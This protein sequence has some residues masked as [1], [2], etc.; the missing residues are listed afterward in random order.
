MQRAVETGLTVSMLV[1]MLEVG[2]GCSI[3][4]GQRVPI[5]ESRYEHGR[6]RLGFANDEP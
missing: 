1:S 2:L 6:A 5:P 3:Y 4:L